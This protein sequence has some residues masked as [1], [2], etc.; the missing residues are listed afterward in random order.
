MH[1]SID[2]RFFG[3]FL[4]GVINIMKDYVFELMWQLT[5]Q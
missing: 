4:M 2:R 1:C 5:K 3:K